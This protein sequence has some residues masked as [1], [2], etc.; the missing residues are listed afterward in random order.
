MAPGITI[1]VVR[2]RG[3]VG[4]A[5]ASDLARRPAGLDGGACFGRGRRACRGGTDR[6]NR[7]ASTSSA[8]AIGFDDEV[9]MLARLSRRTGT[10][11]VGTC[12]VRAL[13]LLDARRIALMHPPWFDEELNDHVLRSHGFE[14]VGSASAEARS[15]SDQIEPA[16]VV[17]WGCRHVQT[18]ESGLQRWQRVPSGSR[19]R[20]A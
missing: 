5:E 10:P 4:A 7:F 18:G 6:C 20:R 8:Y 17:E 2:I 11:V 1:R 9:A 15:R 3:K 14:V 16:A 13:R 12:L 19:D